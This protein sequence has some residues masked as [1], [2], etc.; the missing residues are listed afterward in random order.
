MELKHFTQDGNRYT[1]KTPKGFAVLIIT[2]L[3]VLTGVGF[4]IK[5][6][7]FS[8]VFGIFLILYILNL[9]TRN[10]V[11]DMDKRII[12]GKIA[13][14][15]PTIEIPIDD[16]IRFEF[17][18]IKTYFVTTSTSL[19]MYYQKNGKKKGVMIVNGVTKKL[20]QETLNEIETILG[21]YEQH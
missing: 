14:L 6:P 2:L 18:Q 5:V 16:I 4:W 11:V 9:F 10:M 3:I 21:Q 7:S 17:F 12:S 13:L 1:H 15:R 8:G 19:N 20:I